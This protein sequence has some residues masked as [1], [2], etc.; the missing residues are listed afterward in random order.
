MFIN[1]IALFSHN[2]TIYAS[3]IILSTLEICSN[4]LLDFPKDIAGYFAFCYSKKQ[5]ISIAL[6]FL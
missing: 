5:A 3:M 6:P 4:I 1:L 2:F